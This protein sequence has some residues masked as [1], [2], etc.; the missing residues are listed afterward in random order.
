MAQFTQITSPPQAQAEVIVNESLAALEHVAVYGY[1]VSTSSGLT[2][3]YYGGAWGGFTVATGTLA[4]TASSTNY[5]VAARATGV[6]SVSTSNTNWNNTTDYARIYQV[7]TGASSVTTVTDGRL[8]PSGVLASGSGGGGGGGSTQGKQ[9]IPIVASSMRPSITGG[10]AALAMIT[11]GANQPDIVSLDFDPTTQE[12][13]QFEIP[14]P[15]KWNEGTITVRF[16]WSHAATATNFGVVWGV[17]AV[18]VGDDDTIGVG[19]GTAQTVTD[20]GGT[21][22]DLYITSETSAMTVA[23]SPAAGDTVYIRVYR[24][25]ANGSDTLAI[26]AR[27][28]GVD[29]FITTDAD[30]D[31]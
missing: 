13:A 1:K 14:M 9:V 30:T 17:Q 8:G 27:L 6:I 20:T 12:Y 3:G 10:C 21:T 18:A 23:G 15:K 7:V 4:L 26:D 25:S 22:N 28:H 24:E 19:Y 29:V 16:R 2:W 11:S 5:I 31:A